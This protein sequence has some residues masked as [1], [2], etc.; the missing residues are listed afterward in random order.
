M[1]SVRHLSHKGFDNGAENSHGQL[2]RRAKIHQRFKWP[3]RLKQFL[4]VFAAFH[5]FFYI[6]TQ[7]RTA[8][9]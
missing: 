7:K 9:G 2:Q 4:N 1:P 8:L 5:N 3:G 6:L